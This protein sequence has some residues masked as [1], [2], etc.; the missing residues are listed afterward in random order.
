MKNKDFQMIKFDDFE[1]V[2]NL[3]SAMD[4][5]AVDKALKFPYNQDLKKRVRELLHL[6]QT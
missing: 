4:H 2:V 5:Q 1:E 6:V 3:T